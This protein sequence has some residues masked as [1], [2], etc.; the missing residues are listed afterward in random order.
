MY[1]LRY[2]ISISLLDPLKYYLLINWMQF[3]SWKIQ[4]FGK[5]H[6]EN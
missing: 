6:L 5:E 4:D 2:H 3:F 1:K